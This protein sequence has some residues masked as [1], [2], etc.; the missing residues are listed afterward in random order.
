[1]TFGVYGVRVLYV[2]EAYEYRGYFSL[3]AYAS[4]INMGIWAKRKLRAGELFKG[5][6][7]RIQNTPQRRYQKT[8][9]I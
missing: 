7:N 6:K 2:Y 5:C 3:E 8:S 1:M 4:N 9:K